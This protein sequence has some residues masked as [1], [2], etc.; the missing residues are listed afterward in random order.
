M[1][2]CDRIGDVLGEHAGLQVPQ[3]SSEVEA[4]VIMVA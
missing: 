2:Y 4:E 3:D 1:C